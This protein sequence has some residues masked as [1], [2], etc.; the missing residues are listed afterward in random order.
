MN[1]TSPEKQIQTLKKIQRRNSAYFNKD[2][3]KFHKIV[4]E[5]KKRVA[6]SQEVDIGQ[7]EK[8]GEFAK[9]D[10]PWEDIPF[11]EKAKIINY[12]SITILVSN[13]F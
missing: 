5:E 4:D 12:W 3:L 10:I 7:I 11:S 2:D 8:A 1:T 13:I 6:L 9:E